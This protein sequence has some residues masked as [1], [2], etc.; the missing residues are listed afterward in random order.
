[1]AMRK[2]AW[3]PYGGR[4]P[5][6][7]PTYAPFEV[8][9]YLQIP[10][11][12]IENWAFGYGFKRAPVRHVDPV[13]VAASSQPRLLSFVNVLE[14]HVLNAL[15]RQHEVRL[16][17]IR[18][19][20][21]WMAGRFDTRYPLADLDIATNGVTVFVECYGKLIDASNE[22]QFAMH[23][24]L[25]LHLSRIERNPDGVA[26]RLFPFTRSRVDET[27]KVDAPR[28]VALDPRVAFG[29]P[30]LVGSRVP[31]IEIAER[32]KAGDSPEAL[33]EDYG[34]SPEEIHEAIRCELTLTI[35]AA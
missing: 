14:L 23:Q 16:P 13:I 29:R 34:R 35:S 2:R 19:A 6:E 26:I 25:D 33:A 32:Y 18:R 4:D 5:R 22:G 15:R 10:T 27:P 17:E 7:V 9:R 3:D 21:Q 24:L 11:R 1:M 20:V 28:L 30:V 8:A 31:T 12:T